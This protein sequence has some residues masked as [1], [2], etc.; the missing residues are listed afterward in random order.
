MLLRTEKLSKS[1]NGVYALSNIN[2]EVEAGEVHGLVG[3]NGAGKSTL[4]KNADRCLQY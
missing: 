3:E 2:F 1:F 4:I